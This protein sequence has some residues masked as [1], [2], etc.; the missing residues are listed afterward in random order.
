MMHVLH[1][2]IFKIKQDW[3]HNDM[4]IVYHKCNG[5][6]IEFRQKVRSPCGVSWLSA[7]VASETCSRSRTIGTT[8]W[9]RLLPASECGLV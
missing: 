8:I 6:T 4:L 7:E 1:F 3:N 9:C 5:A 2:G